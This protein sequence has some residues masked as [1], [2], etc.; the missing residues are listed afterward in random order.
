MNTKLRLVFVCRSSFI[1]RK[2]DALQVKRV[3]GSHLGGY[4]SKEAT[5]LY[6]RF[7][8]FSESVYTGPSS[9]GQLLGSVCTSS[10]SQKS[11]S[12]DAQEEAVT[13]KTRWKWTLNLCKPWHAFRSAIPLFCKL[14]GVDSNINTITI[15]EASYT[16]L[17][18][19]HNLQVITEQ[20]TKAQKECDIFVE[21]STRN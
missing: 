3:N 20:T 12:E 17:R 13:G 7:P 18:N 1:A 10:I 15:P 14:S 4:V 11:T 19:I 6:F 16:H 2:L 8:L 5:L 21:F 9:S